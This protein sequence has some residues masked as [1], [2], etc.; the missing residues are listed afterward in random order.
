MPAAA[1]ILVLAAGVRLYGL[2]DVPSAE[3]IRHGIA[4]YGERCEQTCKNEP[5]KVKVRIVAC[6]ALSAKTIRAWNLWNAEGGARCTYSYAIPDPQGSFRWRRTTEVLVLQRS[7]C[8]D[9]GQEADLWC[10]NWI[11]RRPDPQSNV[12]KD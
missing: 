5:E 1:A 2:G 7:A 12:K 10:F 9:E 8:G 6:R 4:F 11:V 3:A